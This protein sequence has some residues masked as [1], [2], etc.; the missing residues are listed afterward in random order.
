MVFARHDLHRPAFRFSLIIWLGDRPG[1][2]APDA[3]S[4]TVGKD[5]MMAAV[6]IVSSKE[7]M[8]C[9]TNLDGGRWLGKILLLKTPAS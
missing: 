4:T 2:L 3:G 1:L 9:L 7:D 6:L 5:E 8:M